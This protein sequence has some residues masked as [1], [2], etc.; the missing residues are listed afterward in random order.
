[1]DTDMANVAQ[2]IEDLEARIDRIR[3]GV[4]SLHHDG[5][6]HLADGNSAHFAAALAES[7]ATLDVLHRQWEAERE[8]S[9]RGRDDA[10]GR[11]TRD[12]LVALRDEIDGVRRDIDRAHHHD[13]P[14]FCD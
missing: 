3:K 1:M 8:G 11:A 5:D 6:R 14:H 12:R 4:A 13:E 7:Q 2:D 9:D 10:H